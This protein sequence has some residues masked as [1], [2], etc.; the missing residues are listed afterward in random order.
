MHRGSAHDAT[1]R[2]TLLLKE[3]SA[4]YHSLKAMGYVRTDRPAIATGGALSLETNGQQL[5]KRVTSGSRSFGLLQEHNATRTP[6]VITQYDTVHIAFPQENPEWSTITLHCSINNSQEWMDVQGTLVDGHLSR[7]EENFNI[8]VTNDMLFRLNL[9]ETTRW[10]IFTLQHCTSCE[11]VLNLSGGH[12]Y[13]AS[14]SKNF[15]ID[16]MGFYVIKSGRLH[17]LTSTPDPVKLFYIKSATMSCVELQW[18]PPAVNESCIHYYHLWREDTSTN[19]TRNIVRTSE[20]FYSDTSVKT[21]TCYIYWIYVVNHGENISV[22]SK[23][24]WCKT[25]G[26][27]D[28]SDIS[29]V[30]SKIVSSNELLVSWETSLP[31][32]T[33]FVV[34]LGHVIG[35]DV[36]S[37]S[38]HIVCG[39]VCKLAVPKLMKLPLKASIRATGQNIRGI[40]RNIIIS[41]LPP[42]DFPS[43]SDDIPKIII[44]TFTDKDANSGEWISKM[45]KN[46]P[47]LLS[48]LKA[49]MFWLPS[50]TPAIGCQPISDAYCIDK[51]FDMKGRLI[52]QIIDEIS[53]NQ[54]YPMLDFNPLWPDYETERH[55]EITSNILTDALQ[56]NDHKTTKL[57]EINKWLAWMF[58]NIG[59]RAL[60]MDNAHHIPVEHQLSYLR[61]LNYPYCIAEYWHHE[62]MILFNY[63]NQMENMVACLDFPLFYALR[64]WVYKQDFTC[65]VDRLKK[66]KSLSTLVPGRSIS[67]VNTH[68]TAVIK[69]IKPIE[70][71]EN[72][73]ITYC[74]IILLPPSPL[75]YF[76][77]IDSLSA[78]N[79]EVFNSVLD[80]RT[81]LRINPG[82][83]FTILE[84]RQQLFA[85]LWEQGGQKIGYFKFG[86]EHWTPPDAHLEFV[87]WAFNI[88]LVVW[89]C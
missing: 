16:R 8:H 81:R 48:E 83:K 86:S 79:K 74:F 71:Q 23:K 30:S 62:P 29:H 70:K 27:R 6:S 64:K 68:E 78:E 63:I 38:R 31:A 75:L 76:E 10:W 45:V 88:N 65:L 39:T 61:A 19:E 25:P 21:N 12:Y 42:R 54:A 87:E 67:F 44:Q 7:F 9:G 85:G 5:C 1:Q 36:K 40:P 22:P 20:R 14:G 28:V 89:L 3:A 11:F 69:A 17:Q 58:H 33:T 52:H 18:N 43:F 56:L 77:D 59:F 49:N 46:L 4:Y 80:I 73:L 72:K 13:K 37:I 26:P 55:S 41:T 51:A 82:T 50:P 53:V 34:T 2:T 24:I 47:T 57:E 32:N 15:I 84:V 60:R 35:M 66:L